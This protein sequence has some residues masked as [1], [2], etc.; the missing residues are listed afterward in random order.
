MFHQDIVVKLLSVLSHCGQRSVAVGQSKLQ[1]VADH[2]LN[3][4]DDFIR[5]AASGNDSSERQRA[6]RFGFPASPQILDQP[7]A[8]LLPGESPLV[9]ADSEVSFLPLKLRH[10][11]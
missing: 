6:L 1:R 5:Q 4:S 8:L 9:N 10:D 3:L 11:F 2:A 7:E